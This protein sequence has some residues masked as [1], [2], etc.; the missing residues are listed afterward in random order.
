MSSHG[1]L[2]QLVQNI[3]FTPKG[4]GGSTPLGPTK[5]SLSKVPFL[6]YVFPVT[7]NTQLSEQTAADVRY[8]GN[9]CHFDMSRFAGKSFFISQGH[10]DSF[11]T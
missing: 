8:S 1:F 10:K 5:R 4:I 3:W 7:V 11:K 6:F 2:A 9:E